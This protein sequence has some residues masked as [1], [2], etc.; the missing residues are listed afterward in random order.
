MSSANNP[1]RWRQG[2][3]VLAEELQKFGFEFPGEGNVEYC[4]VISHDCDIS[5]SEELEP[6]IEV[7]PIR[8]IESCSGESTRGKN[9]RKLHIEVDYLF[10]DG[11]GSEKRLFELLASQKRLVRKDALLEISPLSELL[12]SPTQKAAL[13]LWLAKRYRRSAFPDKF[14]ERLRKSGVDKK[15]LKQ[16]GR[17]KGAIIEVFFDLGDMVEEELSDDDECYPLTIIILYDPDEAGADGIAVELASAWSSMFRAKF[18][19]GGRWREI[20]LKDVLKISTSAFTFDQILK[21]RAWSND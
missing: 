10:E 5:R 1:H 14:N 11:D 2:S 7:M 12:L 15:M 16:L 21:V 17:S 20:E 6:N 8:Q 9:P 19:D 4:V 18:K 13:Q 3:F